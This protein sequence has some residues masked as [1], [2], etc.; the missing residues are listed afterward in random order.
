MAVA[1]DDTGSRPIA[2]LGLGTHPDAAIAVTRALTELAQSRAT[3]I[4]GVR[5]DLSTPDDHVPDCMR[6]IRRVRRIDPHSWYHCSTSRRRN[7][8]DLPSVLHGD[9]V[10][11]IRFM[12]RRLRENGMARVIV[13][14]LTDEDLKMP[15]VRVIVPGLESL[16][17]ASQPR[18]REGGKTLAGQLRLPVVFLG[19]SLSAAKARGIL[20]AEYL[21]PIK[22][23]CIDALAG[24]PPAIGI[25]DGEFFQSLAISPKEILRALERGVTVL[26]AASMGALRAVELQSFG[27]IGVGT[28][29]ELYR[30]GRVD[31]E[32]EVA[33][34]YSPEDFRP[35]SEAMINIRVALERAEK[36]G[37]IDRPTRLR[38]TR[39]AKS[40]YFPERSWPNLWKIARG[41]VE[42]KTLLVLKEWIV[43]SDLST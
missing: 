1:A 36:R 30:S 41:R 19:P 34:T 32:D 18:R 6:H 25:V 7:F 38:L 4:Q 9:I 40:I 8:S 17:F 11:D 42:D 2:H 37:V 14:D 3:D 22:R 33:V 39:I 13:V 27:M 28:V 31:A 23:S 12:I 35:T 26:G 5:E 10:D 43:E 20:E 24:E 15:V 16:G 29:F 21:P